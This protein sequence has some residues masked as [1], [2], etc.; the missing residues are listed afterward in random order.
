MNKSKVAGLCL[1]LFSLATAQTRI[2]LCGFEPRGIADTSLIR[3]TGQLLQDALNATYRFTVIVPAPGSRIYDVVPAAES[4]RAY[5]ATQVLVGSIM[6]IGS[7]RLMNYQLVEA[8]SGIVKLADRVEVPPLEEFPPLA[9][10]IA[11]SVSELKPFGRTMEPAKALKPE[12]EPGV[13]N[14]RQ[15]YSS[16]FLTAGY[17]FMFRQRK[18][19]DTLQLTRNLV[20][21]NMAASFETEPLLTM[22]Q[23][24]LM[25]GVYGESDLSFDLLV[26]RVFGKGDFAPMAGG[27][28]G[29]TRFT[30]GPELGRLKRDGLTLSAGGGVI[31]LRSYYFRLLTAAYG[32]YTIPSSGNWG[33]VP[34]L[35]ICFGVTTPTLGPD[36]NVRLHPACV[37]GIIGGFFLTGLII[38]LTS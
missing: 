20:N 14:P 27:G 4:A 32:T 35:R 1:L 5:G 13:R 24:G 25:R 8:G 3:V 17:H 34:G 2:L 29:I 16:I 7:K 9:E 30:F 28:I 15:P 6:Q 37:G 23:L 31:G 19:W 21:L 10:R 36:A 18:E 22:L 26:N 11:A 38:A 12:V 33:G